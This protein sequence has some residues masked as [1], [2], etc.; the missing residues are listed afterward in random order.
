MPEGFI[1]PLSF[2]LATFFMFTALQILV[3]FRGVNLI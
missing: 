2:N 1:N 3:G